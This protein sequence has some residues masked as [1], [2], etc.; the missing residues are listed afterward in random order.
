MEVK[1]STSTENAL[2]GGSSWS[3][4]NIISDA[5]KSVLYYSAG[6][7]IEDY[8]DFVLMCLPPNTGTHTKGILWEDL[9]L[10]INRS[11]LP[12]FFLSKDFPPL[13]HMLAGKDL[14][15]MI[16]GVLFQLD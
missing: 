12:F 13:M 16:T 14:F 9:I 4:E 5:A 2:A 7:F 10:F 8:F 1:L 11:Y 15:T 3:F 6:T